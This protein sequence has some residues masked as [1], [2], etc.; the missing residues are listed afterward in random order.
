MIHISNTYTIR[1]GA[2]GTL[3][4]TNWGFTSI[5]YKLIELIIQLSKPSLALSGKGTKGFP[6][7]KM[8]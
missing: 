1:K 2:K 3:D 5:W 7:G 6:R 4:M 8:L